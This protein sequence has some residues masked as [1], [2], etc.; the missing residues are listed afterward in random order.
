MPQMMPLSWVTLYFT[1]IATMMMFSIMN[2]YL[3]INKP[4]HTKKKIFSSSMN[5]KW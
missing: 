4:N 1:F 5:W 3:H 2:Y